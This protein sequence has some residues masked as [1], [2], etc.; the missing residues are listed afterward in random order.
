MAKRLSTQEKLAKLGKL[1]DQPLSEDSI[2]EIRKA[3]SSANN[4]VVAKAAQVAA[5]CQRTDLIPE[6]IVAFERFMQ[7]PVKTDKGCFAK[8]ALV[9]ALDTLEIREYDVFLQGIHHI[10][11]E[12]AYGGHEDTA[13]NLR[14]RCALALA[15]CEYPDI[16]F[17]LTTLL[18]DPEPQP[19]IAAIKALTYLN[20]E[21]SELLLRLKAL[22]GDKEP[23]VLS[24][25]F[26]G[27]ISIAPA[28]SLPFVA[29][30]L[31]NSDLLIAEGAAL[32]L[33]ESR[34]MQ[35]FKVLQDQWED[36]IDREVKEM[37]LLPMALTRCD[38]AFKYLLDIVACEYQG[39]AAAAVKAL[40]VYADN[41]AQRE[42]IRNV[43]ASRPETLISETYA[44]EFGDE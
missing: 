31:E 18:A 7:K 21:K 5:K 11:M 17:E 32:A 14:A 12:P 15:R 4:L 43:V 2:K 24:E 37:L 29:G 30:F 13:A 28:H 41:D 1:A 25:C 8:T 26:S 44:R 42:K 22:T 38:D 39:Y 23:Q 27:L 6:L 34:E 16:F 10:Q 33:G 20:E 35:A 19:R 36:S 9:E 40:K 3:L